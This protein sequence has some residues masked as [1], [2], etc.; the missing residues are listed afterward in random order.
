MGKVE[1]MNATWICECGKTLFDGDGNERGVISKCWAHV[2]LEN[3]P[4][5]IAAVK[6]TRAPPEVIRRK[7][8]EKKGVKRA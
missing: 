2:A 1:T 7:F 5:V 4:E 8:R 3:P 6:A